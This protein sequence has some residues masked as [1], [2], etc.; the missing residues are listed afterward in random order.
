MYNFDE[1]IDRRGSGCVKYDALGE[2][3]L[4]EDTMPLWV[5]DMD[6]RTPGFIIDALMDRL[7]HP[8]LG[9]GLVPKDYFPTIAS[10]VETLHGWKVEPDHIRYI[11]GIV[12]GIA[13]AL[14]ALVPAGAKVI[15]MPPVYHPFRFVPQRCGYEVVFN[16]FLPVFADEDSK[17]D[18]NDRKLIG[19]NIDFK[20]LEELMQ[21]GA[22]ALVLAN[23]H[24]PGG[25]V[26]SRDDLARIASLAKRYG[27]LV[28]SDEIHAEMVLRSNC[29][30][31]PF[32]SVSKEAE[33]VSVTF[34]APS[35]T[36]NIPGVVSSYVIVNNEGL[37]NKFF[38][39]LESSE[40]DSPSFFSTVATMAAYTHGGEWRKEMLEYVS[41]N[42]DFLEEFLEKEMPRIDAEIVGTAGADGG[43][44]VP[45]IRALRPSASFLVWLDCR[46]L[47]LPQKD[48][49]ILFEKKAGLF[50]NSGVMF[51]S[52]TSDGEHIGSEGQGFMRLNVACPKS[53]LKEALDK[54]CKALQD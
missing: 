5:A 51:E 25:L 9:Y 34:M 45:V 43:R 4:A 50:L 6:F 24:N 16:P 23:P 14:R 12:K 28:I 10:W 3:G 20:G 37:R 36:F 42:I 17:L 32:A 11:P 1:I 40:M 52:I 27:V 31:I 33:E 48:L 30:H 49:E 2:F 18:I 26:W 21:Q 53:V 19:Y 29:R 13:L 22:E 46:S 44:K 38:K 35:K 7:K 41:G 15:I 54:L 8:V 47:R 39:Y